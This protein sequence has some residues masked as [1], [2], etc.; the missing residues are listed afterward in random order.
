M[1][2]LE[3]VG[4]FEKPIYIGGLVLLAPGFVWIVDYCGYAI[5]KTADSR[6]GADLEGDE[7][8]VSRV[9]RSGRLI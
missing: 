2:I 3:F 5:E 9:S 6:V 4:D 7:V 8:R 1:V